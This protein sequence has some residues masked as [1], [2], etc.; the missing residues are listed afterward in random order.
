MSQLALLSE[1]REAAASGGGVGAGEGQ[2]AGEDTSSSDV[3]EPQRPSQELVVCPIGEFARLPL[4]QIPTAVLVLVYSTAINSPK[5]KAL[6]DACEF[7][8]EGRRLGDLREP[9]AEEAAAYKA[10]GREG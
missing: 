10:A 8:L 4:Y 7:V 6:A 5:Y 2:R 3:A 1:T 9:T